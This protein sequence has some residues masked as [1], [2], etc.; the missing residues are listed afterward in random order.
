M[1]KRRARPKGKSLKRGEYKRH[2]VV[3]DERLLSPVLSDFAILTTGK[4]I[5]LHT[6]Y[7]TEMPVGGLPPSGSV[8]SILVGRYVYPAEQFKATVA[9]FVRQ[10]VAMEAARERKDEA[11]AWLHGLPDEQT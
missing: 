8:E 3:R 6:L 10:Y 5:V 7:Q 1:A 2:F 9:L 11:I 4:D